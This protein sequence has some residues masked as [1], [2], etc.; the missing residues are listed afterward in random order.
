ML[1]CIRMANFYMKKINFYVNKFL[2]IK[3]IPFYYNQY[4]VFHNKPF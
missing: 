3:V 1:K 4:Q 2:K